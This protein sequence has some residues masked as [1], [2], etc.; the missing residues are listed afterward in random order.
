[1]LVVQFV[2]NSVCKYASSYTPT[3]IL[4]NTNIVTQ[5]ETIYHEFSLVKKG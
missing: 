3:S 1:M 5:E 2:S 4:Y